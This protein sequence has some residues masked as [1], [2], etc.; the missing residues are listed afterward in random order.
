MVT[1]TFVVLQLSKMHMIYG[2]NMAKWTY[3]LTRGEN[4]IHYASQYAYFCLKKKWIFIYGIYCT[5]VG[6]RSDNIP[7]EG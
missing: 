7:K 6:M 2:I 3:N 1:I 4:W 5:V